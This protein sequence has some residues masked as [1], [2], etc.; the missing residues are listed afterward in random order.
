MRWPSAPN[1]PGHVLTHVVERVF[2]TPELT[3]SAILHFLQMKRHI[4]SKP[5]A[6][7]GNGWPQMQRGLTQLAFRAGK[8]LEAHSQAH[9]ELPRIR[10]VK[11]RVG[12]ENAHWQ[13]RLHG[14]QPVI[15]WPSTRHAAGKPRTK[16]RP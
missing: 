1:Q 11:E 12:G 2:W 8:K 4:P 9:P 14:V 13:A 10:I 6:K 5:N 7:E 16:G 3:T 15:I